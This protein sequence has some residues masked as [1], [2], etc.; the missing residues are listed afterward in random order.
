MCFCHG[1]PSLHLFCDVIYLFLYFFGKRHKKAV[2]ITN[3]FIYIFLGHIFLYQI[4]PTLILLQSTQSTFNHY[5]ITML[6]I[7]IRRNHAIIYVSSLFQFYQWRHKEMRWTT[8]FR[9]NDDVFSDVIIYIF[10]CVI[11]LH[12]KKRKKKMF[13]QHWGKWVHVENSHSRN[14]IIL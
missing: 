2:Y 1:R 13:I 11:C 4:N 5:F 6:C 3:I 7:P 12:Q 10:V 8:L 14:F 9:K